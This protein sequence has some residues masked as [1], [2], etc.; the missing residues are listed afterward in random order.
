MVSWGA[1]VHATL[2]E[3]GLSTERVYLAGMM[4]LSSNADDVIVI[5]GTADGL[6]CE[7]YAIR[8]TNKVTPV[9]ILIA[10]IFGF[11]LTK[12]SRCVRRNRAHSTIGPLPFP[13]RWR[14]SGV[15]LGCSRSC[16]TIFV[17]IVGPT[18]KKR[19]AHIEQDQVLAN[20]VTGQVIRNR[21][22]R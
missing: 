20:S 6:E 10:L 18:I 4:P 5:A 13:P 1:L 22:K 8:Q 9:K 16:M 14:D 11:S 7:E 15:G 21:R 12:I 17:E 19:A 3:M 2:G